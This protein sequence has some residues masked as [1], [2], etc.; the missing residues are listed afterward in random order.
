M[1]IQRISKSIKLILLEYTSIDSEISNLG[2]LCFA[3]IKQSFHHKVTGLVF[4]YNH[5]ILANT[6]LIT[7][8]NESLYNSQQS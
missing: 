3:Q 4:S 8:H 6:T 5:N 7:L 2:H 1:H